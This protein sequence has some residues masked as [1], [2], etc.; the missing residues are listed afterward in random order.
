MKFGQGILTHTK[1]INVMSVKG[2]VI[3]KKGER[4]MSWETIIINHERVAGTIGGKP[5]FKKRGETEYR[6]Y[7]SEKARG[8]MD[9]NGI[10]IN[11]NFVDAQNSAPKCDY[12]AGEICLRCHNPIPYDYCRKCN[13][14]ST[15]LE[16]S[17]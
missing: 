12:P 5:Y 17:F 6:I 2:L 13:Q 9:Y 14:L 3:V 4:K 7:K 11:Q 16:Y 8:L 15:G 1:D 10:C